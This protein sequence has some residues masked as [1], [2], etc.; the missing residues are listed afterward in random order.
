MKEL[1]IE[2]LKKK[3]FLANSGNI[4]VNQSRRVFTKHKET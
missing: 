1:A 3:P 2:V 4:Q